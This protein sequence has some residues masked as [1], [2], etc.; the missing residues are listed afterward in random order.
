MRDA[1]S[2]AKTIF[3]ELAQVS[4]LREGLGQEA[5]NGVV[6]RGDGEFPFLVLTLFFLPSNPQPVNILV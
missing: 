6:G 3:P 5:R 1:G 2:D 4:L